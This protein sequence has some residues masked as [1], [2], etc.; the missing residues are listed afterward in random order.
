MKNRGRS[1]DDARSQT[2]PEVLS[3]I[4]K[5]WRLEKKKCTRDQGHCR[6]A[7]EC[8]KSCA[9]GVRARGSVLR[10]DMGYK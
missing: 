7:F 4:E 3:V 10:L 1:S 8:D 2:N 9:A 5:Q 6:G